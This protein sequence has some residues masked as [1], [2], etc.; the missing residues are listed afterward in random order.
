MART[1]GK[2]G[3]GEEKE[4]DSRYDTLPKAGSLTSGFLCYIN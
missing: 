2:R 4:Q 1:D 3:W